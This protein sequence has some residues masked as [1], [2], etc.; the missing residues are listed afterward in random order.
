MRKAGIMYVSEQIIELFAYGIK[1]VHIYTMNKAENA[2]E[3][4]KNIAFLR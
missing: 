3:I 1:G 2:K 4:I